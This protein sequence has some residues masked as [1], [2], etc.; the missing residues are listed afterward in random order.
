MDWFENLSQDVRRMSQ[1]LNQNENED[2]AKSPGTPALR[3]SGVSK[4]EIFSLEESD[5]EEYVEELT[6]SLVRALDVVLLRLRD[7]TGYLLTEASL[8]LQDGRSKNTNRLPGTKKRPTETPR[9]TAKRLVVSYLRLPETAVEISEEQ[10]LVVSIQK[11]S[12]AYPGL[13]TI[14]RKHIFDCVLKTDDR[15]L[16]EQIGLPNKT[17]FTLESSMGD[18]RSWKWVEHDPMRHEHTNHVPA[19]DVVNPTSSSGWTEIALRVRLD[20]CDI[21]TTLYGRGQAHTLAQLVDEMNAGISILMEVGGDEEALTPHPVYPPKWSQPEDLYDVAEAVAPGAEDQNDKDSIASSD[22][23]EQLQDKVVALSARL[24]LYE[25][26]CAK[27]EAEIEHL[28]ETVQTYE[29][30][31][32]TALEAKVA[33]E[34]EVKRVSTSV[35]VDSPESAPLRAALESTKASL[36]SSNAKI[37][38]LEKENKVV[39]DML[40][41]EEKRRDQAVLQKRIMKEQLLQAEGLIKHILQHVKKRRSDPDFQ[42]AL[43]GVT[44][45][46]SEMIEEDEA[47]EKISKDKKGRKILK[48]RKDKVVEEE[49]PWFNAIG[50]FGD[51]VQGEDSSPNK[52]QAGAPRKSK[53]TTEGVIEVGAPGVIRE[54]WSWSAEVVLPNVRISDTGTCAVFRTKATEQKNQM[55]GYVATSQPVTYNS[56][57]GAYFE[58]MIAAQR[59]GLEDGLAIGFTATPP[60]KWPK[61]DLPPTADGIDSSW[62]VGFGGDFWDGS[63][64][65]PEWRDTTFNASQLKEGDVVGIACS[66][67]CKLRV[68]VNGARV[69]T[70]KPQS[71]TPNAELYGLVDLIGNTDGVT[72]LPQRKQKPKSTTEET[73]NSHIF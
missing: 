72:L 33:A 49:N 39:M 37:K 43:N 4:L 14:Y 16:L 58:V 48:D 52:G 21:D 26:R 25:Q 32:M 30:I 54:T 34:T 40:K 57:R 18:T 53:K 15:L 2:E 35:P 60:S 28:R 11:E 69:L 6:T 63:P 12:P 1:S 50:W 68:Y 17:E 5:D 47:H 70:V 3:P 31:S 56:K 20:S 9:E 55:H 10:P 29:Q 38:A 62:L 64:E 42:D 22:Y 46:G 73:A 71:I 8:K 24:G 36:E 61:M 45:K 67:E 59:S 7:T 65:T 41:S 13:Q 23:N 66:P 44:M 27:Y 19:L 51:I